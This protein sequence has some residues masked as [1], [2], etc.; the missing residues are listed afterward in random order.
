[1]RATMASVRQ[2]AGLHGGVLVCGESGSGRRT[3]AREVHR[4]SSGGGARFVVADCAEA[5]EIEGVLFGI[6]PGRGNGNGGPQRD[7][8]CK[9]SLLYQAVGGTL[10]LAHLTE[11]PARV[12]ARLARVLR[13]GEVTVAESRRPVPTRMRL[14]ASSDA[15]WDGAVADGQ[16]R[17]D[18]SRR[19]SQTRIL[20]PPLRDRR[21]DIPALAGALLADVCAEARM[22]PRRIEQP[23]M[24]LLCAFPW[25]GNA[26][27]L[28]ALLR[29]LVDRAEGPEIRLQ[30]VLASVHLDGAA[31]SFQ[32][33]GTLRAAKE[34]FERDYILAVLE[35]HRGRVG[36]AARALGIQ[37]PNLYRK[38]RALR[39]PPPRNGVAGG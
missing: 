34:R 21:E 1:M 35:R 12:Q 13:D 38:M 8:I 17:A 39:V 30:D 28:R 25:R 15:S 29:T 22:A 26:T 33:G 11:M 37:R 27:E 9:L 32:G 24:S 4:L 16:I 10:F 23:A 5:D 20:V 18:L 36:E 7:R 2:A 6:P 31:K 3:V 19:C 14:I